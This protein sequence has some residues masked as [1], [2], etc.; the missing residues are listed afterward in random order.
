MSRLDWKRGRFDSDFETNE[1]N[2][3]LR[4]HQNAQVGDSVEYFRIDRASSEMDD[5]YDEGWG[6][7]KKYRPAVNLPALHVTHDEGEHQTT[8][9]GFYFNDNIYVTASFDQVMRTG[10]TL[11]DIEHESYLK[12]RLIYDRRVFRVTQIHVLGQIRTRDVIVSIEGTMVK[13]DELVNDPQFAEY[14]DR[15]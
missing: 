10:L 13:P 3:A 9:S 14:A 4:G 8:D 12:D 2:H 6:V 11:Q 7:G 1:I 5:V 15:T